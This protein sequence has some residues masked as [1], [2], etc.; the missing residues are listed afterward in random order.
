M[1]K[2]L[3]TNSKGKTKKYVGLEE[4][5]RVYSLF[6]EPLLEAYSFLSEEFLH[7]VNSCMTSGRREQLNGAM[8]AP[9]LSLP[10]NPVSLH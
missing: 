8:Y 5:N 2:I 10:W 6:L 1:A 7:V 9:T 3:F 4:T